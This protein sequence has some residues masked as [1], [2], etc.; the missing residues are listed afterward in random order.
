MN[1]YHGGTLPSRYDQHLHLDNVVIARQ[2]I[3][4]VKAP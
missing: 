4:P 1:V 3:G 2:Y